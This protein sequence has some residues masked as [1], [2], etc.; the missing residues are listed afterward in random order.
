LQP[1]I[2]VPRLEQRLRD[3]IDSLTTVDVDVRD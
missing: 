3:A 2:E 1:K